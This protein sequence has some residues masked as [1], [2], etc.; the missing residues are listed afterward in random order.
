MAEFALALPILMLIIYGVIEAG[1]AVFMYAAVNNASREAA[2]F[3]SSDC[4]CPSHLAHWDSPPS[5]QDF[6]EQLNVPM[7]NWK[8]LSCDEKHIQTA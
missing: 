1:R 2:R 3:G 5:L 4:R 8:V 7:S 6:T